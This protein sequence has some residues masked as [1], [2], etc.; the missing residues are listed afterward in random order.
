MD[1][2]KNT[3]AFGPASKDEKIVFGARKPGKVLESSDKAGFNEW[4]SFMDTQ[5]IK[6]VVCLLPHNQL[7]KYPYDLIKEYQRE[8]GSENVCW[9]PIDD[10]QLCDSEIL[11]GRIL[12][13]LT[14]AD[15]L[16]E[17]VVVHCYAGSGRT[18][19]V[20][21]AWLVHG[22]NYSIEQALT[23]VITMGRNPYEA[24][25]TQNATREDLFDLLREAD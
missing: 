14:E 1:R 11:Y 10:F 13:F 4:V 7:K 5:G 16:G 17:R 19:H 24:V 25:D 8:F 15:S 12:P 2:L 21:A 3:Y 18:G 6:R 22:R 20:L 23:A 9:A